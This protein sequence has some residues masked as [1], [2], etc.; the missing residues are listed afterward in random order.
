[1]T[2]TIFVLWGTLLIAQPTQAAGPPPLDSSE[3]AA[4]VVGDAAAVSPTTRTKRRRS[5]PKRRRGRRRYNLVQLRSGPGYQVRTP[6]R[7]YGTPLAVARLQEVLIAGRL[8][9]LG[10]GPLVVQDLSRRGGGKLHPHLSH[11]DGRD[12]DIR[13]PHRKGARKWGKAT[14]R[15]L[16]VPRAW[17]LINGLI[18]TGDLEFIFLDRKLER[19]LYRHALSQGASV[20]RLREIFRWVIRHEPGHEAHV[21]VRFRKG[22]L[23]DGRHSKIWK[24]VLQRSASPV[25]ANR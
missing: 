20:R 19:L 10:F 7:A 14:R 2:K 16:D 8:H 18:Q 11:Q 23:N 3:S 4:Q 15:N 24:L 21:H 5:K 17:F 25:L 9:F 1:M 13:L 6:R 22:R 12:V